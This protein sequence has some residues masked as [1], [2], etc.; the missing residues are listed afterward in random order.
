MVGLIHECLF[1]FLTRNFGAEATMAVKRAAG[2]ETEVEFRIDTAYDDEEWRRLYAAAIAASGHD[3][4]TFERAFARYCGDDL[5]V[6]FPG[7]LR[8]V[9]SAR[10][11]I[12]RQPTIHNSIAASMVE[13]SRREIRDKFSIVARPDETIVYYSSS[14]L[15]CGF[16]KGL[17]EWVA[18]YMSER[19]EIREPHCQ[20]AGARACEIHVRYL[21]ASQQRPGS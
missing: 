4:A 5:V 7:F 20:R 19:I 18:E 6:R 13:G 17:A 1:G 12:E 21:G 2:I 11:L 15:L 16:Y 8:G 9:R 3:A 10:D 14:N